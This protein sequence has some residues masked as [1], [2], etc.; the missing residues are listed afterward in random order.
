MGC[1]HS[2]PQGARRRMTAN[3]I[4]VRAKQPRSVRDSASSFTQLGQLTGQGRACF[5]THAAEKER[6][7]ND[8][9]LHL[10]RKRKPENARR[11]DGALRDG[12]Q[13]TDGLL[14]QKV[15]SIVP[16]VLDV[17]KH[18]VVVPI[19]IKS[20][21]E[22]INAASYARRVSKSA[23][24]QKKA[25]DAGADSSDSDSDSDRVRAFVVSPESTS[26]SAFNLPSTFALESS[27]DD[28]TPMGALLAETRALLN[29]SAPARL[30]GLREKPI[31]VNDSENENDLGG[32]LNSRSF[33]VVEA[34]DG[35]FSNTSGNHRSQHAH[36]FSGGRLDVLH[37]A[38][39]GEAPRGVR[40][41]SGANGKGTRRVSDVT[42]AVDA[43]RCR[44]ANAREVANGGVNSGVIGQYTHAAG[45]DLRSSVSRRAFDARTCV[46]RR[47]RF[48]QA[49]NVS[50]AIASTE[51]PFER[52]RRRSVERTSRRS[53]ARMS[54]TS[55][56]SS[57]S[58]NGVGETSTQ[59]R[60]AS[61]ARNNR[62]AHVAQANSHKV[63]RA[64]EHAARAGFVGTA[65]ARANS[66]SKVVP[67]NVVAVG[68]TFGAVTHAHVASRP[69][70]DI[71]FVS[72]AFFYANLKGL[73]HG[74][75]LLLNFREHQRRVSGRAR[76]RQDAHR[77]SRVAGV[78]DPG[79]NRGA[80]PSC[81]G[82]ELQRHDVP[83]RP[84][85]AQRYQV[86]SAQHKPEFPEN[87]SLRAESAERGAETAVAP[88]AFGERAAD[89]LLRHA[90]EVGIT[91]RAHFTRLWVREKGLCLPDYNTI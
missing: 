66:H 74:E 8:E 32:S 23:S 75:A 22:K 58:S 79:S 6:D 39:R 48:D 33:A 55:T 12:S 60:Y 91:R 4:M 88:R 71:R 70:A 15:T 31:D 14:K 11:G 69:N 26:S 86:G 7:E 13:K 82:L 54:N 24:V 16:Q 5:G 81:S 40:V 51:V 67:A 28:E 35:S 73:T 37:G 52:T 3:H 77:A 59:V 27:G 64:N 46:A 84:R 53:V 62:G 18:G 17:S 57:V 25:N 89:V 85:D 21:D 78:T 65:V 2:A 76:E 80:A 49:P 56:A 42:A 43:D 50:A 83:S 41:V 10:E 1:R 20:G 47:D 29:K 19:Q 90:K 72:R 61:P 45:L 36:T 87:A 9:T 30:H 34:Y 38:T 68:G 44:V 63:V